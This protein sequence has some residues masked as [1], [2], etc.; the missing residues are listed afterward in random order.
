MPLTTASPTPVYIPPGVN[1]VNFSLTI[2]GN[3][4]DEV[5]GDPADFARRIA[6]VIATFFGIKP[7]RIVAP[8]VREGKTALHSNT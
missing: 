3:F 5:G 2:E 7:E 8:F 6:G 1:N 4:T